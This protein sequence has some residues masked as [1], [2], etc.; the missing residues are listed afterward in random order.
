M[1]KSKSI[2]LTK[3]DKQTISAKFFELFVSEGKVI[4]P[5]TTYQL[6][7]LYKMFNL[8]LDL[9]KMDI[10]IEKFALF[11]IETEANKLRKIVTENR[12]KTN[13]FKQY[14]KLD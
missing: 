8:K 2:I 10:G 9:E 13:K 14:F 7:K 12:A 1:R 4:F 6:V 3:N 11:V 5:K